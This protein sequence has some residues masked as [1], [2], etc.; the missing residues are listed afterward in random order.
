MTLGEIFK[1]LQ[2]ADSFD[3]YQWVCFLATKPPCKACVNVCMSKGCVPDCSKC[4]PSKK[5]I[6]RAKTLL[7]EK[8]RN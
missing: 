1:G 2:K 7:E 6:T 4:I 8:E 3:I 5:L